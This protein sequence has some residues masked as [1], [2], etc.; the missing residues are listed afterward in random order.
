[1]SGPFVIMRFPDQ[2]DSKYTEPPTVHV[3]GFTGALHPDKPNEIER[4]DVR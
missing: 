1:M 2:G 3:D 4:C